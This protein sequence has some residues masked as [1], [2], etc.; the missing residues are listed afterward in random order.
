MLFPKKKLIIVPTTRNGANGTS[1]P[2]PFLFK[3]TATEPIIAPKRKPKKS[4]TMVLG[5]PKRRPINKANLTSPNPIAIPFEKNHIKKKNNAAP[6][7]EAIVK[8]IS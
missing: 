3:N 1:D 8:I 2:N 7:D 6:R 4:A 5:K